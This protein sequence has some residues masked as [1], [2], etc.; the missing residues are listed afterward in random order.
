VEVLNWRIFKFF[1][2][3]A[4]EKSGSTECNKPVNSFMKTLCIQGTT[5]IATVTL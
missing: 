2:V 3:S 1:A 4:T 5:C